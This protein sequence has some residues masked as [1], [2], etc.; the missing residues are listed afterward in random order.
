[1]NFLP[2]AD[3]N[4][5]PYAIFH[6]KINNMPLRTERMNIIIKEL[7]NKQMNKRKNERMKE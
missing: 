2:N 6:K 4:D 5:T 7:E 1:M 3:S